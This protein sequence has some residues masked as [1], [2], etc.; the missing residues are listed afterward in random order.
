MQLCRRFEHPKTGPWTISLD[1]NIVELFRASPVVWLKR[2][3]RLS[4]PEGLATWLLTYIASQT[5]LF[6][7]KLSALH[8]LC[9]SDAGEKAFANRFRDAL[10]ALVKLQTI[11]SGWSVKAGRIHW[12]KMNR[13]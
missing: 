3:D 10:R 13:G 8:K 5:R 6:P 11:D 7:T 4:L 12:L 2:Q 9:G 1:P